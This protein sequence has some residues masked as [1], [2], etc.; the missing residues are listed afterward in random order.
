[1]VSII[2]FA[3]GELL[4]AIPNTL[5]CAVSILVGILA[6]SSSGD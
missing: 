5:I 1:L 3:N 4:I 6:E 2:G